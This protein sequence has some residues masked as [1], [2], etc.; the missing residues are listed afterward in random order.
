[1][2]KKMEM[3]HSA[4]TSILSCSTRSSRSEDFSR[5]HSDIS[6]LGRSRPVYP[7]DSKKMHIDDL[8]MSLDNLNDRV[9]LESPGKISPSLSRSAPPSILRHPPSPVLNRSS[10][11]ERFKSDHRASANWEEIHSRVKS[12][13]R[14]HS[15]RQ[16]L[17][18]DKNVSWKEPHSRNPSNGE[19]ISTGELQNS[20]SFSQDKSVHL[21]NGEFWCNRAAAYKGKSHRVIFE[22]SM[23]K[24]YKNMYK[25][26]L[27]PDAYRKSHDS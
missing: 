18:F 17:H 9:L 14:T 7:N 8:Q 6:V 11:R 23:E 5:L 27:N 26:A 3:S 25:N 15:P 12:I 22:E 2:Q 1:M 13:L 10:L 20:S 21:D 19:L 16:K 4:D 24:I